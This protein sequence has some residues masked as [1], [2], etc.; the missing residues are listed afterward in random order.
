G[1]KTMNINSEN[2]LEITFEIGDGETNKGHFSSGEN[3]ISKNDTE[4]SSDCLIDAVSQAFEK[5]NIEHS[6]NIKITQNNLANQI[7][8]DKL[9][10]HIIKNGYHAYYIT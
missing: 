1:N 7:E 8:H 9:I 6:K 10:E 5:S 2:C 3:N 4:N